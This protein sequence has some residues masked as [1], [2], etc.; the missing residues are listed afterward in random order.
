MHS[1]CNLQ[2]VDET[3]ISDAFVRP[4]QEKNDIHNISL[5]TRQYQDNTFATPNEYK[6]CPIQLFTYRKNS[7]V[8]LFHARSDIKPPDDLFVEIN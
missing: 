8:L 6:E 1:F 4:K 3:F 2:R 5:I 7:D